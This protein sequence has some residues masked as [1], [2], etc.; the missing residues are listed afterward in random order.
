MLTLSNVSVLA[1]LWKSS[2][3]AAVALVFFHFIV[4]SSVPAQQARAVHGTVSDATGASIQGATVELRANGIKFIAVSD[5]S[6]NFSITTDLAYGT[7][8]VS[9]PGF[10]NFARDLNADSSSEKIVVVLTP[11]PNLQRLEVNGAPE[12]RIPAVPSSQFS[13]TNEQID[14]S[15]SLVIDDI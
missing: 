10:A 1:Q 5:E 13:I 8:V 3:R 6:G 7:L 14:T 12:D 2:R 9:F 11:A 15:G 4:V